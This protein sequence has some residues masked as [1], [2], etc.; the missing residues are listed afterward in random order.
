M[1]KFNS[2][3]VLAILVVVLLG[4]IIFK[5]AK[6]LTPDSHKRELDSLKVLVV[7]LEYQKAQADSTIVQYK[8]SIKVLDKDIVAKKQTITNIRNFYETKIKAIN[9]LTPTEL[10]E[11]FTDRYK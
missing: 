11:F 5:P 4:Y 8:D 9:K 1:I 6:Q 10:G 2:T 3:T 7:Q